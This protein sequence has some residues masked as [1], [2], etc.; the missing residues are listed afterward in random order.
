MSIDDRTG[1]ER[2]GRTLSLTTAGLTL[3]GVLLG[4]GTTVGFGV[5]GAWWLRLLCGLG[6][7]TLLIA[8]VKLGTARGRGPLVRLA[9][10]ILVSPADDRD[11]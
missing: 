8:A 5:S 6:T 1:P 10:W 9:N 2:T 3:F 4:I 7:T 11:P